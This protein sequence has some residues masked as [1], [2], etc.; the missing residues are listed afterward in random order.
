MRSEPDVS[1]D[2]A[3][4][5]LVAVTPEPDVSV[6]VREVLAEPDGRQLILYVRRDGHDDGG[7]GR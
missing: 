6:V 4:A 7:P 3:A 5:E 1:V 2:D